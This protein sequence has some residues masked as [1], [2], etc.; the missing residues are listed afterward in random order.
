MVR[1][2]DVSEDERLERRDDL[3]SDRGLDWAVLS[4]NDDD[5]EGENRSSGACR[6]FIPFETLPNLPSDYF[7]RL[8]M[9]S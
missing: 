3:K 1:L 5:E 2:R 8:R 9:N 6:I 7:L 4:G